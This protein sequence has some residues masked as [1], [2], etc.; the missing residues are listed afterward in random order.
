[1]QKRL[2]SGLLALGL[3][4]QGTVQTMDKCPRGLQLVHAGLSQAFF[5]ADDSTTKAKK[6]ANHMTKK[7]LTDLKANESAPI[8]QARQTIRAPIK[9]VLNIID[10]G[11]ITTNM[12]GTPIM[13]VGGT[14]YDHD[15]EE[16]STIR[17]EAFDKNKVATL[18]NAHEYHEAIDTMI[19]AGLDALTSVEPILRK[20]VSLK[21]KCYWVSLAGNLCGIGTLACMPSD[22]G[23]ALSNRIIAITGAPRELAGNIFPYSSLVKV[24]IGCFMLAAVCGRAA[25]K[26]NEKLLPL[27]RFSDN[28]V[29]NINDHP[30]LKEALRRQPNNANFAW[31]LVNQTTEPMAIES[32]PPQI[33]N[34]D[35]ENDNDCSICC[36]TMNS[37]KPTRTLTCKHKFHKNCIEHWFNTNVA[38]TKQCPYCMKAQ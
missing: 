16:K 21:T 17:Y 28:I 25:R 4:V 24:T 27:E 18:Q 30:A 34:D 11:E 19:F 8:K 37:I 2:L 26:N 31:I 14:Y 10:T 3:L 33:E 9:F 23:V 35:D 5:S 12:L 7:L 32:M 29:N 38:G 1:M 20:I 6:A 22:T 36:S 15:A 13:E